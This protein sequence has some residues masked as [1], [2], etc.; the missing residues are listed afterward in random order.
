[1]QA[2]A[3]SAIRLTHDL[4]LIGRLGCG[5][6]PP[7]DVILMTSADDRTLSALYRGA[8]ARQPLDLRG[9]RP[10]ADR[11][12]ERRPAHPVLGHP[13]TGRSGGLAQYFSVATSDELV[14]LLNDPRPRHGGRAETSALAARFTWRPALE[15]ANAYTRAAGRT[16]REPGSALSPTGERSCPKL[17][18]DN[19]S[20]P[21]PRPV[22]WPASARTSWNTEFRRMSRTAVSAC[23]SV[24]GH[25]AVADVQD[26]F[27]VEHQGGRRL[28]L[29][30]VQAVDHLR[31]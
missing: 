8:D 15:S 14:D 31:S 2:Y 17:S 16:R 6:E 25:P 18:S 5:V 4:R 7:T 11:G 1:M 9:L 10:S 23:T 24:A 19:T 12:D 21:S 26:D 27:A 13:G 20:P 29:H 30:P 3:R 28:V 22:A